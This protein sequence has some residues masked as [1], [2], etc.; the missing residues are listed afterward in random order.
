MSSPRG[1]GDGGSGGILCYYE[2]K[3][4]RAQLDNSEEDINN[5]ED[6]DAAVKI[7]KRWRG[8]IRGE[9]IKRP[10]MPFRIGGKVGHRYHS[11]IIE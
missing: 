9:R 4:P 10:P 11:I 3:S 1:D 8:P 5:S 2:I 7:E 6:N